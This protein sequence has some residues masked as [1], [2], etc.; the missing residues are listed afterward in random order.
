MDQ[1]DSFEIFRQ[2]KFFVV[3]AQKSENDI[4]QKFKIDFNQT[5]EE[6][7][8]CLNSQ[9]GKMNFL[10]IFN[11]QTCAFSKKL[12]PVLGFET[13]K[14]LA[15]AQVTRS[16][17]QTALK[18]IFTAFESTN[19]S[20]T[21]GEKFAFEESWRSFWIGMT[22]AQCYEPVIQDILA[23]NFS[24]FKAT[25]F[26]DPITPEKLQSHDSLNEAMLQ[27]VKFSDAV[28]TGLFPK[29]IKTLVQLL[30]HATKIFGGYGFTIGA[31]E[32]SSV[33]EWIN[34]YDAVQYFFT[35]GE[36][37]DHEKRFHYKK[38]FRTDRTAITL[39]GSDY[40]F[41]VTAFPDCSVKERTLKNGW[42]EFRKNNFECL[43]FI[44]KMSSCSETCKRPFDIV[45]V[46]KML[47][48]DVSKEDQVIAYN[49]SVNALTRQSILK[50]L[51]PHLDRKGT[52]DKSHVDLVKPFF[53]EQTLVNKAMNLYA[54]V[55]R[56]A[57]RV[58]AENISIGA[59]GTGVFMI[60][61][62]WSATGLALAFT[63]YADQLKDTNIT[64][65]IA[66]NNALKES[67]SK[68]FHQALQST[69]S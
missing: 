4:S 48:P 67:F 12:F 16:R 45:S 65:G 43:E 46:V 31:Q 33:S 2:T 22:L 47:T 50:Y 44:E 66:F 24:N 59:G 27:H 51:E 42:T 1:F 53:V 19:P 60:P 10:E 64:C 3:L 34:E 7:G 6:I 37:N 8:A 49:K 11:Q 38:E 13:P 20:A 5:K 18:T 29:Q 28:S 15:G 63:L 32:E 30:A 52:L 41:V 56:A 35:V 57:L 25:I 61:A 21:R 62:E 68:A 40:C 39:L 26:V 58:K 55:F 23:S 9:V 14:P 36:W 17:M 54:A 69:S